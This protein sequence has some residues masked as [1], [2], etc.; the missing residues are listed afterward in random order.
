MGSPEDLKKL[1]LES[2]L[3]Y[4]A[5]SAAGNNNS[6]SQNGS[7]SIRHNHHKCS[8]INSFALNLFQ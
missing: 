3:T 6:I 5:T 1:A 2:R 4:T 8:V 7:N